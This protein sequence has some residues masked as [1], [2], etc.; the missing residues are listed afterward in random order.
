MK[1]TTSESKAVTTEDSKGA[2]QAD[3]AE[4]TVSPAPQNITG[5]AVF[6]VDTTAAGIVVRTAFLTEQGQVIDMPAV[7]PDLSYA[8]NQIDHLRQIVL[9]R[10]S[11]AAQVGVQVIAAN[12]AQQ[13]ANTTSVSTSGAASES[14]DKPPAKA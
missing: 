8:L 14:K 12:A 13:A 3:G 4:G 1:N 5:R 7:F 6:A 2:S 11:Q 9:E 10:F